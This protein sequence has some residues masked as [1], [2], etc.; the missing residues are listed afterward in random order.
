MAKKN[1]FWPKNAPKIETQISAM[2]SLFPQFR[3]EKSSC[4][5]TFIGNLQIKQELPTYKVK[6]EY[7]GSCSPRVSVISPQL[8][9]GAP[10]LYK[11]GYLCLYYY[12]NFH[13][14]HS[15]LV[16]KEVMQWTCA[17][18]YFYEYWLQT[19]EWVGPAVPHR[20]E[21]KQE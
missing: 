8:V 11:E 3:A 4:G 21:K 6:V 13:W 17:W 5:V 14:T 7:R 16:A 10:H 1:N 19:G 20:G 15:K 2:K 9:K 12:E 18:L